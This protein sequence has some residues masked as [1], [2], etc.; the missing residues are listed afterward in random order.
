MSNVSSPF[1]LKPA[2]H[3]SGTVRQFQNTIA[4][5]YDTDIFQYS[6]VQIAADGTLTLVDDDAISTGAFIGIFEGVEWTGTDGRR[7]VGNT[8]PANTV[9]SDIVAYYTPLDPSLVFQMQANG[10]IVQADIGQRFDLVDFDQGNAI[11]GLSSAGLDNTGNAA[12][13]LLV[14][15]VNPAPDNV[16]GDDFT[17]VQVQISPLWQYNP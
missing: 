3:P 15:G 14:V 9:G 12:G 5:G 8:W 16:V 17:T 13:P 6:P 7:R 11:T 2:F 10:P 1:G 4:S